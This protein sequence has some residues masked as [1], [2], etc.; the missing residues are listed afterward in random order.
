MKLNYLVLELKNVFGNFIG[1][2][3]SFVFPVLLANILIFSRKNDVPAEYVGD[4]KTSIFLTL[5]AIIPISLA[6]VGFPA[7][8]SQET[9]KGVTKRMVLFGY[10]VDKQLIHKVLANLVVIV[11]A[12]VVYFLAVG[13]VN[14]INEPS[15][16]SLFVLLSGLLVISI[17]FYLITFS[18]TWWLKKF[19]R[20][21]GVT[22]ILYFAIMILT[23]MFGVTPDKFGTVIET[24]AKGIPI[25]LLNELMIK[26]WGETSYSLGNYLYVLIG[27][28]IFSLLCFIIARRI[29][30]K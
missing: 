20:V 17:D 14:E 26:N 15:N 7:L 12:T 11:L 18:I 4:F 13:W 16:Y 21:Y 27:F 9:E 1:L 25:T 6:L 24:I 30:R 19:S 3:F 10:T 29:N 23:G 28:T 2:F 8:F 22:M 5:I